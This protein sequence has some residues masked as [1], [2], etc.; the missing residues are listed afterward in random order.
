M[1]FYRLTIY[2]IKGNF[3]LY[4][5]IKEYCHTFQRQKNNLLKMYIVSVKIGPSQVQFRPPRSQ[6]HKM[7]LYN[8]SCIIYQIKG[9]SKPNTMKG[10]S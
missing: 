9:H 7:F 8:P 3:K 4:N 6:L 2:Q 10:S 5:V 1:A